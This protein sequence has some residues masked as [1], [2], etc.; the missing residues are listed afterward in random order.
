[1]GFR[2][3]MNA[4]KEFVRFSVAGMIVTVTDFSIYYF[5]FHFLS[6]SLA[7]GISFTC[8]GILGYLLYKYWTF[9]HHQPSYSEV[10]RYTLVSLL[11]L[12]VN[13]FTNQSV[14]NVRADPVYIA[15]GIATVVTSLVTFVGFKWWVF[16]TSTE[17]GL[18]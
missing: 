15:L 7:K 16:R 6:F 10:V 17:T 2:I 4:G 12:E 14:L 1:M 18:I 11:A 3:S 8:A 13:V 5:L 9:K